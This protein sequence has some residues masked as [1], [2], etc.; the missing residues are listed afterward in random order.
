MTQLDLQEAWVDYRI[1]VEDEY[2][3]WDRRRVAAIPEYERALGAFLDGSSDVREF[4]A[5][6]D[7]LGKSNPLFGFGG[8]SQMFFNQLV[9][10]A[11]EVSTP[12]TIGGTVPGVLALDIGGSGNFGTFLPGVTREQIQENSGWP[13]KFAPK[14][15]E[16][17]AP[18]H[19]ELEVLRELHA[20]TNRAH[21]EAA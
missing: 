19:R 16:T 13:I 9:K 4:R 15:A 11:D 14:V 10:A 5:R 6:I 1:R 21:A 18:T 2:G 8:M 20:R 12:V 3:D 7:S 17:P